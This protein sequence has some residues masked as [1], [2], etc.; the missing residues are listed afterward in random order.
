MRVAVFLTLRRLAHE[1]LAPVLL[2]ASL[3]LAAWLPLATRALTTRFEAALTARADATP[4]V[5]GAAGSDLDLTLAA[6]YFDGANVPPVPASLWDELLGDDGVAVPIV[7][8]PR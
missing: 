4:L 1:P 2:T 8:G 6:L 7:L 5:A 3:A